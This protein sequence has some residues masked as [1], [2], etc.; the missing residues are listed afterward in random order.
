MSRTIVVLVHCFFHHIIRGARTVYIASYPH[1]NLLTLSLDTDSRSTY[2]LTLLHRVSHHLHLP[3]LIG[4][5]IHFSHRRRRDPVQLLLSEFEDPGDIV[6]RA[7]RRC[8]TRI[9][10][11]IPTSPF[12]PLA[13][14]ARFFKNIC[15]LW[16]RRAWHRFANGETDIDCRG[17]W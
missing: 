11:S 14:V 15:P 17:D 5:S 2:C 12:P 8:A 3:I 9:V 4:S 13:S 7:L 16:N 10:G 1:Y 6:E